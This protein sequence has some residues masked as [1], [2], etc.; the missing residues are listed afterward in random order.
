[1]VSARY[2]TE[3]RVR[4]KK[5]GRLGINPGWNG[6]QGVINEVIGLYG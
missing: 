3:D 6:G 1:M 2:G 4:R 5:D